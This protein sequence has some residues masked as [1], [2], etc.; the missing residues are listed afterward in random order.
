MSYSVYM[1]TNR[2]RVV[3]YIGVTNNLESRMWWHEHTEKDSFVKRYKLNR[4]VYYETYDDVRDAIAREKQI[5]H[6]RREKK[7]HLV[8]QLNPL[9]QDLSAD[10]FGVRN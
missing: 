6:W 8:R 3:L 1:L 7:N 2:S 9:W 10:L 5:K 4:I